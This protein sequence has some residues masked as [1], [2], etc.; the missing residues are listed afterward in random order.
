MER[1]IAGITLGIA[2]LVMA[3]IIV[4][5]PSVAHDGAEGEVEEVEGHPPETGFDMPSTDPHEGLRSLGTLES[6]GYTVEVYATQVGTRYT[7]CDSDG[8]ELGTLLTAEQVE[9]YYPELPLPTLDF[10]ATSTIMLAEPES[11]PY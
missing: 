3:S 7:V 11:Q 9:R 4:P 6:N 10:S 2:F 8:F 1:L 5:D